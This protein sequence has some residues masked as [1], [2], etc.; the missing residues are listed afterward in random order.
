MYCV[1]VVKLLSGDIVKSYMVPS[2]R[3]AN[4]TREVLEEKYETP[5]R[6]YAVFTTYIPTSI[7]LLSFNR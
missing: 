2:L 6:D 5:D 3:V 1:T 7:G 4:Q